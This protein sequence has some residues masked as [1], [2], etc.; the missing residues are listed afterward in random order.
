MF[1]AP[2]GR[3][4]ATPESL[5]FS[6]NGAACPRSDDLVAPEG[7]LPF[8]V[9]PPEKALEGPFHL[10]AGLDDRLVQ[11]GRLVSHGHRLATRETGLQQATLV[12]AAPLGAVHVG[13]VDLHP[14]NLVSKP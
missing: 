6:P 1:P 13:E 7:G 5:V 12:G 10:L 9:E 4:K 14:G 3:P 11:R 2:T 8:G